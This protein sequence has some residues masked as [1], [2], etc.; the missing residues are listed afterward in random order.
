MMQVIPHE[1]DAGRLYRDLSPRPHRNADVCLRESR[2]IVDPI[3]H[4]SHGVALGLKPG[5]GVRFIT[6]Q[7]GGHD[8]ALLHTHLNA[9]QWN[10]RDQ[11]G[12]DGRSVREYVRDRGG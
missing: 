5:H 3:S 7:D 10:Q 11:Y 1:H 12:S 4:E 9:G 2:A 6:G 8:V